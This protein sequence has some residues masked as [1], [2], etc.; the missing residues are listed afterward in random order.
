MVE[1]NEV[2]SCHEGIG[3]ENARNHEGDRDMKSMG[4]Q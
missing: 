2:D 1:S 3:A 4:C